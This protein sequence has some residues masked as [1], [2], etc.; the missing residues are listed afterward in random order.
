M[1]K[2][3]H[4]FPDSGSGNSLIFPSNTVPRTKILVEKHFTVS[5]VQDKYGSGGFGGHTSV[6]RAPNLTI[7][8][9]WKKNIAFGKK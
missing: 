3:K 4:F 8:I 2:T 9:F 7:P 6:P 1:E 5:V